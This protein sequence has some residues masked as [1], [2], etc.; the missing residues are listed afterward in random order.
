V[1]HKTITNLLGDID[2]GLSFCTALSANWTAPWNDCTAHEVGG[3]R[4]IE[5]VI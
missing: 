5:C 2:F 4:R 1:R 3:K